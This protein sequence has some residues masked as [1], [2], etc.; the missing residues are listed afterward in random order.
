MKSGY[1]SVTSS[2][3]SAFAYNEKNQQLN[4]VFVKNGEE[5]Q[6]SNVPKEL[7]GQLVAADSFGSAFSGLIKKHPTRFPYT[8]V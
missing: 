4:I 5:Y 2:Q 8:K 3:I 7:V 1:T 6:Y